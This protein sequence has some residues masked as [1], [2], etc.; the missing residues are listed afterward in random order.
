MYVF[1]DDRSQIFKTE[2]EAKDFLL[3]ELT[4]RDNDFF[5]ETLNEYF[6]AIDIFDMLVSGESTEEICYRC[7]DIVYDAAVKE[8]EDNFEQYFDEIVEDEE[9]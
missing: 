8:I 3:N 2:Q 6:S 4:Q 5:T 9:E 7:D 1:Y